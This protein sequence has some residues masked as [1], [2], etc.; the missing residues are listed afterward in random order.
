[1][2]A[3]ADAYLQDA[4]K[5][6]KTTAKGERA[7]VEDRFFKLDEME[8]FLEAEEAKER[9]DIKLELKGKNK[10]EAAED[11]SDEDED[12]DEMDLFDSRL[13]TEGK[14][15]RAMYNDYFN[16]QNGPVN[17]SINENLLKIKTVYDSSAKKIMC[18]YF[19]NILNRSVY[20]CKL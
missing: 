11:E 16:E 5:T 7:Q 1:M 20:G 6:I 14:E 15:D 8:K 17:I 10:K 13:V 19:K 4:L 9:Q 18:P 3:K 12:D 2:T